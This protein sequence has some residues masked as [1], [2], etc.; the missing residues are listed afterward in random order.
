MHGMSNSPN[1]SSSPGGSRTARGPRRL[2]RTRRRLAVGVVAALAVA[3][4]TVWTTL[5]SA[6]AAPTGTPSST[7]A[8]PA[9][10]KA[11]TA[12]ATT[13]F[14]SY[15]AEA[16][17]LGGGATKVSQTS[18]PTTKYSSAALEA[19][20]LSYAHLAATGQSV[21]W[22]N[23]TGRPI[24]YVNVR[25]SIPDSSNGAGITATLDLYVNGTF[26]Q[27]LNLNS[28]QTWIYE[29]TTYNSST[30]ENPADGSPR[31]FWDESRTFVTGTPI[32]DGDTLQL[33]KDSSNTASFYDID[34]IDVENPPAPLAQ[35]DNSISITSCGAVASST[36]TNGSAAGGAVDSRAAIQTCINQAQTEK[37]ILWIPE[38]TFYV[39]GTTGLT[40]KGI[41]IAGAG[42]W[43]SNIYR[44]VPLPETA[45]FAALF[46]VTSC[47]VRNF[48]IDSNATS[49]HNG[50]G[51]AMDTTGTNWVAS[52]VWTQHTMSGFWASGTGGTVKDNRL[53]SIWAD[54]I[55]LNNQALNTYTGTNLTA[56]NNFIRGTGDD[57]LA[58]NSVDHDDA[59]PS[60]TYP[61]MSDVTMTHNTA[62]A[63]WGAHGVGIYGGSGHVVSDNYLADAGRMMALE[64]GVFSDTGSDL[65]SATVSNNVIVR[66]GGNAYGQGAPAVI[67]GDGAAGQNNGSISNVTATGNTISDSLYDAIGFS[68]S[69]NTLLKNNTINDP[70]RNGI[71]IS[72]PYFTAPSGSATITGN[73][74]TGLK[75]GMTAYANN[76]TGFTATVT[77]NSWQ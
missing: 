51:G 65:T 31:V 22:T 34:V 49:R 37:K 75:S 76:S 13:P 74:V 30:D 69:H 33:K 64:A 1:G 43:Y 6:N 42:M 72:P 26:R 15:E 3:A 29:G 27:A 17:T 54:G 70:G 71:V 12:G 11:T 5:A 66:S 50:D 4:G 60:E 10:S 68:S 28:K 14:T 62:I 53:T 16:G 59:D 20:G 8:A 9:A 38:G 46:S 58:I 36:P 44:N 39:K 19:S 23:N 63:P 7:A 73:T 21:Q 67:I 52:G 48:H 25:A 35:P 24:T 57:S 41:T 2:S 32:A 40:A 61:P 45:G 18:A 56:T 47:T 77:D 55:N